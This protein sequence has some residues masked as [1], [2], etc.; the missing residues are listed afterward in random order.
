MAKATGC[1]T[2]RCNLLLSLEDAYQLLGR[3]DWKDLVATGDALFTQREVFQRIVAKGDITS[4]Q[5]RT[6]NPR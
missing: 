5:S 4:A 2:V 1:V 6:T 3:L